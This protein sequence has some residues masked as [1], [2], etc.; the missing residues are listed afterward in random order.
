MKIHYTRRPRTGCMLAYPFEEKRLLKWQLPYIVQRKYNG[1]RCICEVSHNSVNLISSTGLPIL[2]APHIISAFRNWPPGI[3]DGEIYRHG[4]FQQLGLRKGSVTPEHYENKFILFD[5]KNNNL[6][7]ITRLVELSQHYDLT[8]ASPIELA[9]YW[10]V[11]ALDEVQ[12]ILAESMALGF[13]GIVLREAY[14]F[15]QEKRTTT[16]MKIK[17]RSKDTYCIVACLEEYDI[18][19]NPKGTLGSFQ[20]IDTDGK[21]FCVGSGFTAAQRKSYWQHRNELIGKSI[22]VKYQAL[23]DRGVPWFPVFVDI[24]T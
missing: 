8:T 5:T 18:Q 16:M 22:D 9:P 1:E 21:T 12:E 10:A 11:N 2:T 4:A 20:V 17:P 3:Y 15:Y 7:Q 13:E 14:A 23:T 19:N 24:I 6:C